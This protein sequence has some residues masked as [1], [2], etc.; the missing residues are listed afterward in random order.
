MRAHASTR[1][2]C[3]FGLATTDSGSGASREFVAAAL[4]HSVKVKEVYQEGGDQQVAAAQ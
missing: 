3:E 4:C 1:L 2:N